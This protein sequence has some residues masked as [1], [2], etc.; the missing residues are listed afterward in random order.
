MTA[1]S[2]RK[3]IVP[4]PSDRKLRV[5]HVGKY[6]CPVPGG[7]ENHCYHLCTRLA[8]RVD[9]TVLV[10]HTKPRTV[11]ETIDGVRVI[12]VPRYGQ[13]AS[14]PISQIGRAHV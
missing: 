2:G 11:E 14:T 1:Y 13:V 10:S 3:R 7:I 4:E 9:L 8:R 6:Y 12:R 5:V